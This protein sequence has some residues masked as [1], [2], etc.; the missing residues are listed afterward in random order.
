M[1]LDLHECCGKG[2]LVDV[3]RLIAQGV[4]L[5]TL[6]VLG[7]SP[8]STAIL[9]GHLDIV[10]TLLRAGAPLSSP[11]AD[12]FFPIH[13]AASLG[14]Y[15]VMQKLLEAGANP[16]IAVD[17]Y[18]PLH[19]ACSAQDQ[20]GGART[21]QLLSAAGSDVRASMPDDGM[22]A[23]HI[24]ASS[25]NLPVLEVLWH[26]GADLGAI[27]GGL[28][29][30]DLARQSWEYGVADWIERR[31][32]LRE[33][34]C[35][36]LCVST[37]DSIIS[38]TCRDVVSNAVRVELFQA[39][40]RARALDPEFRRGFLTWRTNARHSVL[41]RQQGERL[42]L[43]KMIRESQVEME[44][45]E[46]KA[47][48]ELE[49]AQNSA[50]ETAKAMIAEE[51]RQV[52]RDIAVLR[53]QIETAR[54]LAKERI[55]S[56]EKV[57][58]ARARAVPRI[59]DV[60]CTAM[61][62]KRFLSWV[63]QKL[64]LWLAIVVHVRPAR[65]LRA[66]LRTHATQDMFHRWHSFVV[67]T[68]RRKQIMHATVHRWRRALLAKAFYSWRVGVWTQMKRTAACQLESVNLSL[69]AAGAKK[70]SLQRRLRE[71]AE[72]REAAAQAAE[73]EKAMVDG[74]ETQMT[75]LRMLYAEKLFSHACRSVARS[76][77][78]AWR[79]WSH[80]MTSLRSM[81]ARRLQSHRSNLL[82]LCYRAWRALSQSRVLG[83]ISAAKDR[84]GGLSHDADGPNPNQA[85][86]K[87]GDGVEF[88][89]YRSLT[90]GWALC[91]LDPDTLRLTAVSSGN[92]RT[93]YD[94]AIP[95]Y[96]GDLHI[97]CY[98]PKDGLYEVISRTSS[99]QSGFSSAPSGPSLRSKV[100]GKSETH[101][102]CLVPFYVES[103]AHVLCYRDQDGGYSILRLTHSGPKITV[104]P[105]AAGKTRSAFTLLVPYYHND[106]PHFLGYDADTGF[107]QFCVINEDGMSWEVLAEGYEP[108][109][110]GHSIIVP[111]YVNEAP[112][113][114]AYSAV[115]GSWELV[116]LAAHARGW[117]HLRRG[118][119]ERAMSSL[120]PYYH[121][122]SNAAAVLDLEGDA[123][124]L[125]YSR[126]IGCC[127]LWG[128]DLAEQCSM[129]EVGAYT[130]EVGWSHV[131]PLSKDDA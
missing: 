50:V 54:G 81:A 131:V 2:Q 42:K 9:S 12:G 99:S 28:S 97:F 76:T 5:N 96:L 63:R 89:M 1:A 16:R 36:E 80:A 48:A 71:L 7:H 92:L 112:F 105:V 116:G 93:G 127:H 83:G 91:C 125:A 11:D 113:L 126:S 31:I 14:D 49:L 124:L 107:V 128:L 85:A 117:K 88:F 57:M 109:A 55:L 15:C 87:E 40:V 30:A 60:Y 74:V 24:A 77:F 123:R 86:Y 94:K 103:G 106:T 75:R 130:S 51:R 52:L 129:W 65:R 67:E 90:G 23:A 35:E 25:G 32:G 104:T 122:P 102:S 8:L 64:R 62:R 69:A 21:V 13:V 47:K 115:N 101:W 26:E 34:V 114:L 73:S 121:A 37:L 119:W 118:R 27:A 61:R 68:R 10:E 120:V 17:G 46:A 3:E 41:A 56:A 33:R 19:L 59:T 110:G 6:D 108:F 95:L 38:S 70:R 66:R 43:Q 53:V 84:V 39:R 82:L 72:D 44:E 78:Q 98:R 20:R 4:P 22:T 111:F 18:T 45:V 29:P 100:T 58:K 79:K